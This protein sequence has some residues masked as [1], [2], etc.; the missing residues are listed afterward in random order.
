M[1]KL[2]LFKPVYEYARGRSD[3]DSCRREIDYIKTLTD[4]FEIDFNVKNYCLMCA[5][6]ER[7]IRR[8]KINEPL[9][10]QLEFEF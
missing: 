2:K 9:P 10:V 7:D 6:V 8:S 4:W 1:S 5:D 3:Y